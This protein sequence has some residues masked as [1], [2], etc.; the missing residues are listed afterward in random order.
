MENTGKRTTREVSPQ[1]REKIRASLKSYYDS[2][3]RDEEWRR[4][5]SDANKR[6]WARFPKKETG[7]EDLI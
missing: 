4:K 3:E 7:I 5:L 1:V 2:H 6:A